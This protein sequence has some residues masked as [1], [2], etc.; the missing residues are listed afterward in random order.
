LAWLTIAPL[1]AAA[2]AVPPTL[3]APSD[4]PSFEASIERL[5]NERV[6]RRTVAKIDYAAK[7]AANRE[8]G[9]LGSNTS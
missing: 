6:R 9:W 5:E 7:D 1:E 3:I 8:L 2:L 4:I